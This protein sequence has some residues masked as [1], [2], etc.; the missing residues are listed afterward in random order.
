MALSNPSRL[1]PFLTPRRRIL[2][3]SVTNPHVRVN[4]AKI[5]VRIEGGEGK[6]VDGVPTDIYIEVRKYDVHY[7][8]DGALSNDEAGRFCQI[9]ER[10]APG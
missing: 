1:R 3:G 4:A 10:R 7:L 8:S 9:M 6:A 2:N 5:A